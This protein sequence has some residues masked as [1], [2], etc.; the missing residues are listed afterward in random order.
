MSSVFGAPHGT[1]PNECWIVRCATDGARYVP[2]LFDFVSLLG[3]VPSPH[4]MPPHRP[5]TVLVMEGFEEALSTYR[6]A[7]TESPSLVSALR[8]ATTVVTAFLGVEREADDA[9]ARS[10]GQPPIVALAKSHLIAPLQTEGR[11][12]TGACDRTSHS[13]GRD[14]EWACAPPSGLQHE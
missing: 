6:A 9:F 14:C 10:V 13:V 3:C 8:V 5:N 11:P 12:S 1:C 2:R 7:I 4:A